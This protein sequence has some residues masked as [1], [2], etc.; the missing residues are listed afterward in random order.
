MTK[1]SAKM[2]KRTTKRGKTQ[3]NTVKGL[4]KK[5]YTDSFRRKVVTY[6]VKNGI[7]AAAEKY[8]VSTPSVTNWRKDF[9]VTRAT[10]EAAVSGK[11]VVLPEK[12]LSKPV[13]AGR[14]NYPDAFRE[15]VARFSALEGIEKTALRFGVSSPSVTNWRREFGINRETREE[16]LKEQ[17]KLG[18]NLERPPGKKEIQRVRKH[19][20]R[21]LELIDN[22]L[23]KM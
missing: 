12:P 15:E 3:M 16:I 6:S 2:T 10:K 7:I 9:G 5:S 17:E 22:L 11:K 21:S 13:P 19:V 18:I 8:S 4:R 1:K 14:K 20:E 23:A